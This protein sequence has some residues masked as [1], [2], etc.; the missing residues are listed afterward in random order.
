MVSPV[1]SYFSGSVVSLADTYQCAAGFGV[2]GAHSDLS[3]CIIWAVPNRGHTHLERIFLMWWWRSWLC[4]ST[5]LLQAWLGPPVALT[6]H[7]DL[8]PR[9]V[10][11]WTEAMLHIPQARA[12]R[13]VGPADHARHIALA[14]RGMGTSLASFAA[15]ASLR[16]VGWLLLQCLRC[17]PLPTFCRVGPGLPVVHK[18]NIA[19]GKYG[20]AQ[21]P[22]R[23]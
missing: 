23:K 20:T 19:P 7:D 13:P 22:M 15:P 1:L 6:L 16:S 11:E 3:G 2:T 18:K 9:E 5:S 17:D 4:C 12:C 14:V 8:V 10:G 21:V